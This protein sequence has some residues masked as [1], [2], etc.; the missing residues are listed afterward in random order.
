VVLKWPE[1]EIDHSSPSRAR[2]RMNGAIYVYLIFPH[3]FVPLKGAA[4]PYVF[5]I[6]KH[7]DIANLRSKFRQLFREQFAKGI[8]KKTMSTDE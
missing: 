6:R 8:L 2:L 3:A 5:K 7:G 4:V 1:V